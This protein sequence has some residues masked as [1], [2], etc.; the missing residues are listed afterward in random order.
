MPAA[1][2]DR[3]RFETWDTIDVVGFDE[4]TI[5]FEGHYVIERGQPTSSDWREASVDIRMLELA[6]TGVSGNFGRITAEINPSPTMRS[7]GQ[8]RPGTVYGDWDSPKWC[9][10]YGYMR[11]TLVDLG[12]TVFNREP[13]LLEHKITHIPPIGQGGGTR[14]RV[15]IPLYREQQAGSA[16][17]AFLRQVTTHIGAWRT[18]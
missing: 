16:P 7:G 15:E 10:M 8:V 11:F 18:D 13:I 4:E 1:G 2:V 17:V 14:G 12:L 9:A 6:V 3:L 5:K